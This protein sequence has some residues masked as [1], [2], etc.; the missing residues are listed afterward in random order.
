MNVF[1]PERTNETPEPFSVSTAVSLQERRYHTLKSG[2]TFGVFDRSG[3]ILSQLGGTDGLYH[4]DTRHLSHFDLTLGGLRPLLLSTS[5]AADNLMLTSDVSNA[6]MRDHGGHEVDQ[7]V[8]H[9]QRSMFLASGVI[10][11]RLSVR[12]FAVRP[13]KLQLALRFAADFVD[14]FEVRGMSR[15]RRGEQLLAK[16]WRDHVLL[17]YRGLDGLIWSTCLAFQP[18]PHWLTEKAAIFELELGPGMQM[19]IFLEI[20]C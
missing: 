10:H 6:V 16:C 20:A 4:E 15:E 7:G 5:L 11:G 19:P 1:S 9:V 13:L 2:D 3:D 14:L 18:A 12:S 8:V 17:S